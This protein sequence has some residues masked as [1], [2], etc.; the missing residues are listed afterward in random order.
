MAGNALLLGMSPLQRELGLV[1]IIVLELLPAFYHVAG[2]A[3]FAEIAFVRLL[4]TMAIIAAMWGL[5]KFFAG[6]VAI[7]AGY[8]AV[9][10]FK[11][12]V[13]FSVIKCRRGKLDQDV[14]T[15]LVFSVTHVA[16]RLGHHNITAMEPTLGVQI[17][18]N[19]LVA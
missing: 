15:A 7:L 19:I 10:P 12:V 14:F 8:F 5:S 4:F 1:V 17:V 3:F 9:G 13:G 2:L 18:L 16:F 6:L 11:R